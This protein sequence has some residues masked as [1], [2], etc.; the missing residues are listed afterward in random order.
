MAKVKTPL[1]EAKK[2]HTLIYTE[3]KNLEKGFTHI[4]RIKKLKKKK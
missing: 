3:G 1:P 2:Q 4:V